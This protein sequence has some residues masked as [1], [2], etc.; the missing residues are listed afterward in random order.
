MLA[1]FRNLAAYRGCPIAIDLGATRLRMA[2]V[3]RSPDGELTLV[4]AA[5]CD[6]PGDAFDSP[7]NL[8]AFLPKAIRQLLSAGGFKG[9]NAVVALP[10]PLVYIRHF[11]LPR[12]DDEQTRQQLTTEIAGKLPVDPSQCVLR[13]VIAGEV[14]GDGGGAQNEVIL[15]AAAQKGV[16]ALLDS[17]SAAK[18]D[19]SGL[20][21][22]PRGVVD[23]FR[24]VYRRKSDAD[25][26]DLLVDLG[27]TTT[28]A[29]VA[30]EGAIRFVRSVP[31]SANSLKD[32]TAAL[33]LIDELEL[34]RRYYE[35]TFPAKPV[36]RLIFIGGGAREAKR[37][38]AIAQALALPAQVGDPFVRFNGAGP[39]EAAGIDRRVANPEWSVAIGLSLG[40]VSNASSVRVAA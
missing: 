15:F 12:L 23:C 27:T 17:V 29:I 9:R 35:S 16:Q 38:Q 6:V 40:P 20:Q 5:A 14:Y 11:R 21:A 34:C 24:H 7:R 13:H 28:R 3:E 19:V 26:I 1:L 32:E 36:S 22:G 10:A 2:Q 30:S 37:C 31:I 4:A 39:Y 18:L 33:K 8:H 25:E